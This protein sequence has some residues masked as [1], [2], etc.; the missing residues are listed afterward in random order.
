MQTWGNFIIGYKSGGIVITDTVQRE[1]FIPFYLL[2][3]F[4]IESD[5]LYLKDLNHDAFQISLKE[6]Q[7]IGAISLKKSQ[8][9]PVSTMAKNDFPK[10]K[11]L[12]EQPCAISGNDRIIAVAYKQKGIDFFNASSLE[13]IVHYDFPGYSYI[14]DICFKDNRLYIADVFGLRIL[15]ITDIQ[16]PVLNDQLTQFKGWPKDIAVYSQYV[17]VADVLGIKIYDKAR[18]FKMVGKIES[19]R[20]RIAKVVND[21]HYAFCSCEAVGLKIADLSDIKHPKII[22]G[23]ILPKGVWDCAVFGKNVYLAAYTQ[24]LLKVDFSCIKQLD[25][26]AV[27]HDGTEI[28]GVSVNERGV[29]CACSHDGFKI[30]DHDLNLVGKEDKIEGR[31]W[32]ILERNNRIYVAAGKVGVLIYDAH[33]LQNP[34]LLTCIPTQE[35]RDLCLRDQLLYIADGQSGALVYDIHDIQRIQ[36][37]KHIPTSAFTR[38]VMVDKNFIYKGDG[39]G[40]FEVYEKSE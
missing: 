30:F 36:L 27:Y 6:Y 26:T 5:T 24:G 28:I 19:N 10:P 3:D 31:C 12:I 9:Y 15:D 13:K 7:A 8:Y 33:N 17:I 21:S 23:L 35:S 1:D 14:D 25:R 40:G 22:S 20:N 18:D 29:F 37:R 11:N 16:H 32:A 39:D 2:A 38:G 34:Q 4:C